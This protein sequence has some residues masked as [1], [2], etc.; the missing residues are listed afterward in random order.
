MF[1]LIGC[2]KQPDVVLPAGDHLNSKYPIGIHESRIKNVKHLIISRYSG[3]PILIYLP[4]S[5]KPLPV[6]LFQ[7]GRPFKMP[8]HKAYY[9]YQQFVSA[10]LS[11]NY[12]LAVAIRSGYFG[13]TKGDYEKVPC[14]KPT[15]KNFIA[16]SESA[17]EDI[18]NAIA[19]LKKQDFIDSNQIVL[20]G[21]SAGGFA[22][23]TA[24]PSYDNDVNAVISINGGRCGKRGQVIGGLKSLQKLYNKAGDN[25]ITPVFFL[26]GARDDVIPAYS[27]TRLYES[28]CSARQDC[29]D[30]KSVHLIKDY[31]GDHSI[32]SMLDS[33][34]EALQHKQ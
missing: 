5:E 13:S 32:T 29:E 28:F 18:S 33:Y 34:V 31:S 3:N 15:Y 24:L 2:E 21:S 11:N 16:A 12:A 23:V 30:N 1:F 22:S 25:S 17:G 7:H 6:V 8:T 4:E 26:A 20:A 19:Y 14:N 10:T 9:P 27:T